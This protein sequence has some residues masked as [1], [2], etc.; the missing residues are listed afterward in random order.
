MSDLHVKRHELKYFISD[1]EYHALINKL[2]YLLKPDSHST[3]GKGY[4][5]RSLYFDSHDDESL[6]AKLSG[7]HTRTKYRLRLYDPKAKTLKFEIKHKRN[8]QI[9][10]QSTLITKERAQAVI[11]GDYS[12]LLVDNNPILH[13]IYQVFTTKLYRPK[14]IVDYIRDAYMFDFFNLRITIDKYLSA[15]NT[16]QDIFSGGLHTLP[17]ILEQK[18]IL[19]IKYED[20]LPDHIRSMVQCDHFERMAISKYTLARR[21]FKTHTWEDN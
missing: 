4:F 7:F 15:T 17:V 20:Y 18:H 13:Q 9:F 12:A 10:K 1:Q 16:Q 19:E 14:V 3:P 6:F 8:N 2:R 11:D 5:I 21:F